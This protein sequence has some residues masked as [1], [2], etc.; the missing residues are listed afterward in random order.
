[1]ARKHPTKLPKPDLELRTTPLLSLRRARP[2]TSI[3]TRGLENNLNGRRSMPPANLPAIKPKLGLRKRRFDKDDETLKEMAR[4]HLSYEVKMLRELAD[5][6]RGNGVGPRTMRNALLE[7]FLIHYRNL[8]DFFYPDFPGR[9]RLPHDICALDYLQN[10][11]R[12]RKKRPDADPKLLENRER[13]NVLLAHLTLRRLRYNTRSWH[14]KKMAG[15]IEEL[16][17]EFLRELPGERRAWFRTVMAKK[18][19][20]STDIHR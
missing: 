10:Q 8:Y 19:V 2:Q 15:L 12:W 11:K 9:K 3:L 6:L 7:S 1:M 20:P 16:L 13:V 5:A 4:R 17:Q 18:P 14:D